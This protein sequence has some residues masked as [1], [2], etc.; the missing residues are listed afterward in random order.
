MAGSSA[1]TLIDN[2]AQP[3]QFAIVLG[4]EDFGEELT[5]H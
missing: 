5:N 4:A 3:L 1:L 2:R